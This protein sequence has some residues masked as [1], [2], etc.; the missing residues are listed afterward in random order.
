MVPFFERRCPTG[1]TRH[2]GSRGLRTPA[3]TSL[4]FPSCLSSPRQWLSPCRAEQG[5]GSQH[6]LAI[7]AG[8]LCAAGPSPAL[9]RDLLAP[10]VPWAL[11]RACEE[12][13]W[14]CPPSPCRSTW[15]PPPRCP[16]LP[17]LL[18]SPTL[19]HRVL[20]QPSCTHA[21]PSWVSALRFPP[22]APRS[23]CR[24]NPGPFCSLHPAEEVWVLL[25]GREEASVSGVLAS[26]AELR[27]P[28][29][30]G[31]TLQRPFG[32]GAH[33]RRAPEPR[34]GWQPC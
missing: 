26:L 11:L 4:T 22:G 16:P 13:R 5:D 9:A 25:A 32:T 10:G 34:R 33:P 23:W 28:A 29:H 27:A 17:P 12:E 3:D 30:R 31:H 18:S 20:P 6:F 21:V 2:G 14:L 7:E 19:S 15:S 24:S 8:S 1:G